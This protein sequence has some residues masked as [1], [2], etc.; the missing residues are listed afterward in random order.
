MGI[1]ITP[2]KHLLRFSFT[3]TVFGFYNTYS[4]FATIF[5]V[6]TALCCCC[7]RSQSSPSSAAVRCSTA[8]VLHVSRISSLKF[9]L[10]TFLTS[11]P[12]TTLPSSPF[13]QPTRPARAKPRQRSNLLPNPY[14]IKLGKTHKFQLTPGSSN[15]RTS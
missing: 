2:S 14:G 3:G 7:S 10:R 13:P 12:H 1:L 5:S 15:E 11:H 9:P 4:R 8:V 6:G